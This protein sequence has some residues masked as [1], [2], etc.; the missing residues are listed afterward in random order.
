[1]CIIINKKIL[2]YVTLR[3][4]SLSKWN[5]RLSV[6]CCR[7]SESG[8]PVFSQSVKTERQTTDKL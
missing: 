8:L 4:F 2:R 5:Y 6:F 3:I 7:L 1:M